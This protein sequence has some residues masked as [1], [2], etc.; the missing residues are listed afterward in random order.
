MVLQRSAGACEL[1][2]LMRDP[3]Q[4]LHDGAALGAVVAGEHACRALVQLLDGRE[5]GEAEGL[6]P[7]HDRECESGDEGESETD[8]AEALAACKEILD[9]VDD[10]KPDPE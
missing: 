3:E 9:Q 4:I 10:A 5:P 8:D 1:R 7:N 2:I 6:A